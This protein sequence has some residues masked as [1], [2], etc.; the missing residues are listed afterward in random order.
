MTRE[1]EIIEQLSA[2]FPF[3]AEKISS[4]K[5]KRIFTKAV[6]RDEF[7]QLVPYIK[8]DM[9][10]IRSTHVIGTDEGEDLGLLY[11]FSGSDNILLA[12]KETVPKTNPVVKSISEYY[13]SIVLHE[14]E[15]V[16]LFGIIIEGLPEG[17]HF[18]LPDNWPAGN[19][20]MR[21]EWKTEKFDKMNLTYD[22]ENGKGGEQV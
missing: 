13:L 16:D 12:V 21:K 4:Y 11:V 20:P 9:K 1:E 18:P 22:E 17:P 6:S 15:L 5:E 3:M 2:K 10:F 7:E 14:R 8:Y 19:Y